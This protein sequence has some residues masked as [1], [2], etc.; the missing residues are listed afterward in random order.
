MSARKFLPLFSVAVSLTI[1]A[2]CGGNNQSAGLPQGNFTNANLNGSYAFAVTGT[3]RGGFFTMAGSL[4]A[5]GSGM[6][7]SG[8]VDINSPGTVGVVQNVAVTGTYIVHADGRGTAN[9]TG[10]GLP[11]TITLDFVLLSN[12][13]GAVIRFDANATA[14][15]SLD[16]Q[17]SS[18]FNLA[19]FNG[20]FVFNISGVDSG[21]APEASTGVFTL[22]TLGNLTAG[23]QDT[24]DNG[25][26]TS[27]A[28]T[29]ATAAMT[30]PSNSNGRGTLTISSAAFPTARQFVFYVVD[31][32]T[33]RMIAINSPALAGDAFRETSTTISG[34][35]A[36]TASGSDAGVPFVAGGILNT[37]GAG[38][39]LG[40]SVEDVNSG[41]TINTG[42]GLSG[43]FSAVTNGR[44][45]VSLNGGAINYAVYPSDAGLQLLR[46]DSSFVVAGTAFQQSGSFSNSTISGRYGANI[47]G[48]VSNG[49]T[50]SE[51]D[52]VYQLTADGAGNLRG[53]QD[54]NFS[55]TITTNLAVRGT[56]P[57]AADGRSS[58]TGTLDTSAGNLNVIYYA[59]SNSRILFIEVDNN[60][61][62]VGAF[63]QQQ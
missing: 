28:L 19:S 49:I 9:L 18:A 2:G 58:S 54:I 30:A 41:G 33:I 24:S 53:A 36:F 15:G 20:N 7:T 48:V 44:S 60:A 51:F 21:R 8:T 40:T 37:D 35:F 38:N 12:Q 23:V 57:L 26:I 29:V 1:L 42:V 27:D 6:I 61:V 62:A 34:S 10:A 13:H 43:S 39:V 22:D 32:N 3:N 55:G 25:T 45:T 17:S 59:V 14:S 4:A 5:N 16:L 50:T 11:N 47:T 46:L 52:A 31:A 56:A 63:S